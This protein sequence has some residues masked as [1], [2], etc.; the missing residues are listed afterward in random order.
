VSRC[1]NVKPLLSPFLDGVLTGAEREEVGA[2]VALC[3][4]CG[5]SVDSLKGLSRLLK[6]LGQA[7]LPAGFFAKLERKRYPPNVIQRAP[8]LFGSFAAACLVL[9]VVRN[10]ASAPV[11]EPSLPMTAASS[12]S[13]KNVYLEAAGKD[14][15]VNLDAPAKSSLGGAGA[16]APMG[17]P[18]RYSNN[19]LQQ[20]LQEQT[21]REGMKIASKDDGDED[22]PEPFMGR[23]M[24]VADTRE[25]AEEAIRQ[26]AAI[27]HDVERGA[28]KKREVP[29]KGNTAPV[30]EQ[31]SISGGRS[32]VDEA[33]A[34]A[35]APP[36]ESVWN[37]GMSGAFSGGLEGT[38]TI[39]DQKSWAET[40][41]RLSRKPLP[42][43][44][45]KTHEIV[46]VFLGPRPTGGY[47]VQIRSIGDEGPALVVRW[48]ERAPP[49]GQSPPEG[50]TSP[51]ALRVVPRTELPVR[52]E[53]V[54]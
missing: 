6:S 1:E 38:R 53:K 4:D 46:A 35:A 23:Q 41:K 30:F 15:P 43:V 48:A 19:E 42:S 24:G 45:F 12:P 22:Q 11:S 28:G 31:R 21:R 50:K 14:G 29:I 2:H 13:S 33:P 52:Y 34:P 3:V 18:K 44:D 49:P 25:Q 32:L 51:F 54:P 26:I 16:G 5:R 7:P 8:V 20:M 27:R 39:S 47:E 36:A 17:A 10:R 40:W 37:D 9:M